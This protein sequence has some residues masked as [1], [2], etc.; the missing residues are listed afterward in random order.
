MS[1]DQGALSH[2][3]DHLYFPWLQEWGHWE[4]LWQTTLDSWNGLFLVVREEELPKIGLESMLCSASSDLRRPAKWAGGSETEQSLPG[5][6][7]EFW[8]WQLVPLQ[9]T[10]NELCGVLDLVLTSLPMHFTAGKTHFP[11]YLSCFSL[12]PDPLFPPVTLITFPS[13]LTANGNP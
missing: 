10:R 1:S 2:L 3:I 13:P 11:S 9:C 4:G 7:I 6:L 8:R 12:T 5:Q